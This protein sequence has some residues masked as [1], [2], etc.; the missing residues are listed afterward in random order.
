M[1]IIFVWK[2]MEIYRPKKRVIKMYCV[3]SETVKFGFNYEITSKE[4]FTM[5]FFGIPLLQSFVSFNCTL[6][7]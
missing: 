7:Q 5:K 6:K 2:Y 4:I 3:L 1:Q